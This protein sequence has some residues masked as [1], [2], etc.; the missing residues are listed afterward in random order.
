MTR[1]TLENFT[2]RLL[3]WPLL[4][5]AL[6]LVSQAAD[7]PAWRGMDGTIRKRER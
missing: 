1:R 5:A 4:V 6:A 2:A 3:L 7:W